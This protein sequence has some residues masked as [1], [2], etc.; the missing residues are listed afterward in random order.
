MPRKNVRSF[1]GKPLI[2]I[3]ILE[4]QRSDLDAFFV[5]TEDDEIAS[6]A[7]EY[8]APVPFMRPQELAGDKANIIPVLI[9]CVK[10]FE[11][12]HGKL[13]GNVFLLQPTS[14]LRRHQD[15]NKAIEILE[16]QNIDSVCSVVEASG[17]HPFKMKRIDDGLLSDF[18]ETGL[19]NPD[20]NS[21]PKVYNV[22]GCVYAVRRN[23]LMERKTLKGGKQ[24]PL[25]MDEMT[26][27][28]IDTELDFEIC[29]T[30]Y[31]KYYQ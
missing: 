18:I 31:R 13:V 5:S 19:E 6:I 3:S 23:V 11:N 7:A 25:V 12:I 10:R 1:C 16:D 4:A 9:D 27:V 21:L 24:R 15:I 22:N 26:S 8:G 29:E 28:S 14:P 17:I 30:L 2:S 20:R